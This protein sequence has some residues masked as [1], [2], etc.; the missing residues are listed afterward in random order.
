MSPP[1]DVWNDFTKTVFSL[2]DKRYDDKWGSKFLSCETEL[3]K[4]TSHFELLTWPCEIL[5]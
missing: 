1:K 3:S 2:R 4:M 5:Y